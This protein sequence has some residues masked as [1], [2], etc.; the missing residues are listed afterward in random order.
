M[1]LEFLI[2]ES[3][4]QEAVKL[5]TDQIA[6]QAMKQAEVRFKSCIN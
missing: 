2:Q 3:K 4:A 1:A 5:A 6:A